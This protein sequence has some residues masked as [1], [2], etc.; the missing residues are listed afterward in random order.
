[1]RLLRPPGG[2]LTTLRDSVLW[3]D[4]SGRERGE[5]TCKEAVTPR[6]AIFWHG[7]GLSMADSIGRK[8]AYSLLSQ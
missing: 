6:R 1:M 3:G 7:R 5:D 2:T 8:L 4:L